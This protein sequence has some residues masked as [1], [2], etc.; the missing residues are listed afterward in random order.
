[1]ADAKFQVYKDKSGKFRFRLRAP[2]NKIV[3]VGE[4][5]E[6]RAGCLKGVNA[7]KKY[8][9]SEI[10]DLTKGENAK[11]VPKFQVFK[12]RNEQFRFNLLAPNYEIVAVSESYKA[13]A[14]CLNGIK[15][16]K[17]YCGAKIEDLTIDKTKEPPYVRG[18]IILELDKPPAIVSDGSK[19]T[20][21]GKLLE[22]KRGVSDET[23]ELYE[24]D[25]SFMMDDFLASGK[26]DDN[27]SFRIDWTAKKMDWWDDTVEVYARYR[28]KGS[29][30]L[31]PIHSR[32]FVIKIS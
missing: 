22:G 20:F 1:M 26:T 13:H 19:V 15:A 29:R 10:D 7:V 17:N 5:Y 16:V 12:D 11:P 32:T 30:R 28:E 25:R 2:N 31:I 3:T 18:E 14:G 4:A 27:G 6:T 21:T 24:S 8:C 9:G 23:I